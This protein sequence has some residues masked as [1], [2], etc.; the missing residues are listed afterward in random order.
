[1]I[2]IHD[3]EGC[4]GLRS[5]PRFFQNGLVHSLD[6]GLYLLLILESSFSALEC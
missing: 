2:R 6:I 5:V 3:P 4:I 1:L